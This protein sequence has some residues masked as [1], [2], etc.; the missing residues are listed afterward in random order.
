MWTA[1][2]V[3]VLLIGLVLWMM[4]AVSDLY[5]NRTEDTTART[6]NPPL[7]DLTFNMYSS[8]LAQSDRLAATLWPLRLVVVAWYLY[9]LYMRGGRWWEVG[10]GEKDGVHGRM[11]SVYVPEEEECM[12]KWDSD[13]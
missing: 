1:I 3:S 9:C 13:C 8:L 10:R 2:G 5:R 11:E 4:G 12:E 6:A 7:R